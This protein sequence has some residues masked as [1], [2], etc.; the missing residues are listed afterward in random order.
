MDSQDF[1]CPSCRHKPHFVVPNAVAFG[2]LACGTR[3]GTDGQGNWQPNETLPNLHF[4]PAPEWLLPGAQILYH[5]V[6]YTMYAVYIHGVN[7][8]EFDTEDQKYG[9]GY[10]EYLEYYFISEK[11]DW[12]SLEETDNGGELQMRTHIK[13][14]DK[15]VAAVKS[16]RTGSKCPEYGNFQL[17][18]FWGTDD[19]PLE[20]NHRWEYAVVKDG[21]SWVSVEWKNG[22]STAEWQAS[23]LTKIKK[24]DLEK[25]KIRSPE[26][27]VEA[28]RNAER[29]GFYRDVFGYATLALIVLTAFSGIKGNTDLKLSERWNF[30]APSNAEMFRNELHQREL[31]VV[32]LEAGQPYRFSSNCTFGSQNA[33]AAFSISVVDTQ[34][35]SVVNSIGADFFS[36]TGVDS[37]GAW[38]ES[39]LSDYFNFVA[40]KSG[41]YAIVARAQPNSKV[42]GMSDLTQSGTL[43]I[44][45]K[46]ILMTRFFL[47]GMLLTA[48]VWLV[49]QWRWEYHAIRANMKISTWLQSMFK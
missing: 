46:P 40:E 27:M 23:R 4:T 36:E 18:G 30:N 13:I 42:S 22:M 45:V 47:F 26:E 43:Y 6:T 24:L 37:D 28:E 35:G 34:D 5:K 39:T 14:T 49:Y 12:F 41:D 10:D 33:S 29:T 31:G 3:Y 17:K 20:T 9:A 32:H 15:L 1:A 38:S 2:C 44:E 25:W 8:N 11:G 19:E 21:A 48:L 16:E 7:W